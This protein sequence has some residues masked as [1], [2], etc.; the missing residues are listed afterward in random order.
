MSILPLCAMLT[1]E[2]RQPGRLY[3]Q[4]NMMQPLVH[5]HVLTNDQ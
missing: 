2:P 4:L 1:L 5:A 3:M